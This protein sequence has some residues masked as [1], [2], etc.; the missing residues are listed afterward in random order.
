MKQD[1]KIRSMCHSKTKPTKLPIYINH[2][3]LSLG[4]VFAVH[5]N[6]SQTESKDSDQNNKKLLYI[7]A[8][9]RIMGWLGFVGY[10]K[11]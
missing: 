7:F 11:L 8:L 2:S 9:Y 10:A 4:Q 6:G 1:P 3:N 5:S